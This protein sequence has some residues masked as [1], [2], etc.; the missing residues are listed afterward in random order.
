MDVS[1]TF[2]DLSYK[3]FQV[4][5]PMYKGNYGIDIINN[6]LQRIFNPKDSSKKELVVGEVIFREHAI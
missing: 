6:Q 4:L 5:A 3:K 1:S 2:K